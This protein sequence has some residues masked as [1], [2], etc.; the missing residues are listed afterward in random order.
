MISSRA[1]EHQHI[2]YKQ[3]LAY[4]LT[5]KTKNPFTQL[6]LALNKEKHLIP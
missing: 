6:K 2:T 4:L 1:F 5:Q 3:Q